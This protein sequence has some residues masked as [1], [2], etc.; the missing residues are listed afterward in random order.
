MLN[1]RSKS[2]L[3][4]FKAFAYRHSCLGMHLFVLSDL[5]TV[6]TVDSSGTDVGDKIL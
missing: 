4:R 6:N 5:P 3:N 1:L 2:A